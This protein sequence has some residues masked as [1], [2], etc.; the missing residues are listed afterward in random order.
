MT[1]RTLIIRADASIAMGTGHVMRCLALAQ[2]WQDD[3]GN[4]VFAMAQ[5]TPAIDDH[6]RSE[7]V[8]IVQLKSGVGSARNVRQVLDLARDRDAEWI[9][10][11]GYQ[12]DAKYQRSLKAAGL[13]V[14]FVDDTGQC[15]HYY[16][17]SYRTRMPMPTKRC[18]ETARRTPDSCWVHATPCFGANSSMAA[19]EARGS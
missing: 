5:S 18:T 11:D 10:V 4:A 8:E 17:T 15:E 7:Q 19:L 6:L 14:L 12:F 13:K 9:M 2:A 3:G 1:L 16:A